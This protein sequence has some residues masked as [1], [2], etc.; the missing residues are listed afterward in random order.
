MAC[1]K[2][3]RC[4]H[5]LSGIHAPMAR[6]LISSVGLHRKDGLL[7]QYLAQCRLF[8][9]PGFRREP[10]HGLIRLGGQA[11]EE[12]RQIRL[13]V[14]ALPVA[15]ADERVERGDVVSAGCIAHEQPV[16]LADAAGTDRVLHQVV[17]DLHT[18][19]AQ[20]HALLDPLVQGMAERL[21]G[22]VLRQTFAT[23]V[24]LFHARF[25]A[26]HERGVCSWRVRKTS[27]GPAHA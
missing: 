27:S 14:D 25:E 24:E 18:P 1:F 7:G 20:E 6:C 22:Q 17:V 3:W 16:L 19:L 23:V 2:H 21:T 15:V 4:H 10:M 13:G 5:A 12:V 11:L 9:G 8:C 26:L